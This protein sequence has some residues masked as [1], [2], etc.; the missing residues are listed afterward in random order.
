MAAPRFFPRSD[1]LFH[2]GEN[3]TLFTPTT[4]SRVDA[5]TIDTASPRMP[6]AL[7]DVSPDVSADAPIPYSPARPSSI[8]SSR[9]D[10]PGTLDPRLRHLGTYPD[11]PT[12]NPQQLP[13]TVTPA[14]ESVRAFL[15]RFPPPLPAPP[16]SPIPDSSDGAIKALPGARSFGSVSP[17]TDPD[18][19]DRPPSVRIPPNEPAQPLTFR[20]PNVRL[21][22][23]LRA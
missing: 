20:R 21:S 4:I 7:M 2:I 19:Q 16:P 23:N 5:S 9:V 10:E 3:I 6:L 22:A 17:C 14:E 12:V 1:V 15:L 11:G 13:R 18:V 8:A